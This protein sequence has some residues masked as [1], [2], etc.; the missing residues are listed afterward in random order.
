MS[1]V[2]VSWLSAKGDLYGGSILEGYDGTEL[3]IGGYILV[4]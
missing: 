1:G 2:S 4:K 3:T